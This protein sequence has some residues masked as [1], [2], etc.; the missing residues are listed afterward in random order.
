MTEQTKLTPTT[1]NRG[2][3][4]EVSAHLRTFGWSHFPTLTYKHTTSSGQVF[5]DLANFV[6]RCCW[7]SREKINYFFCI[8]PNWNHSEKLEDQRYHVH[9]LLELSRKPASLNLSEDELDSFWKSESRQ[10][11]DRHTGTYKKG[12]FKLGYTEIPVYDPELG[13]IEYIVK[14]TQPGSVVSNIWYPGRDRYESTTTH[15]LIDT[16]DVP[17]NRNP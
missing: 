3:G 13:G 12:S 15:S 1:Q 4:P 5:L 11:F 16:I 7:A 10:F 14:Q 17:L 2:L 8:V 9:G 6:R